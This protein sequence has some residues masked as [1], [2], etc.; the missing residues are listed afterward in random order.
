MESY[1]EKNLLDALDK[2]RNRNVDKMRQVKK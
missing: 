1:N 2:V